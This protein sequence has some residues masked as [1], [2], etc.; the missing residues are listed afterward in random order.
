MECLSAI[1]S[2]IAVSLRA[3]LYKFSAVYALQMFQSLISITEGLHKLL[4]KEALDLA[5]AFFCKQA[6]CDT[7]KGKR[8]DAFTKEVYEKTKALCH[9]QSIPEPGAKT[10]NKQRKWMILC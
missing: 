6:V 5:E 9:T 2:P 4:Q 10:M 3:K 1:G 7:L 8:A